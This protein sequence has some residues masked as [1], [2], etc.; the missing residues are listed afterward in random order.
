MK[1]SI[2]GVSLLGVPPTNINA[3]DAEFSSNFRIVAQVQNEFGE[4]IQ[5]LI[6]KN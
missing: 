6:V 5:K 2:N 3:G 1:T 4:I